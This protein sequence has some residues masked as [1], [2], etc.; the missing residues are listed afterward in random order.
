MSLNKVIKN[1]GDKVDRQEIKKIESKYGQE[2]L[3]AIKASDKPFKPA[4]QDWFKQYKK[5][6]QEEQITDPTIDPQEIYTQ[7]VFLG[8][9]TI[10]A[11]RYS[12]ATYAVLGDAILR[13]LQ[14]DIDKELQTLK[15][16]GATDVASIEAASANYGYDRDYAAKAYMA[17]RGVDIEKIRAQNNLDLQ[18]I[19]NSGL[20]GVETIRKDAAKEAAT[21]AGEYGVK[22][23]STRQAG[24]KE[25][26]RIGEQS[27]FRNAL[28]GAFNF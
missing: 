25:I 10:P 18:A 24:Q 1:L 4:A 3:D 28:I 21:I 2:G 15:N 19:V 14:G 12:E 13:Q 5:N 8:N 17:D 23:E 6:K 26:A 20:L 16:T 11:G 27:S 22:Q 9:Y 7:G